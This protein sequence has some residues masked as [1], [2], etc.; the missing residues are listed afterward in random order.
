M[1][2]IRS[3]ERIVLNVFATLYRSFGAEGI[4]YEGLSHLPLDDTR[5]VGTGF[6]VIR[7]EA[8]SISTPHEHTADEMFYVL[9][10]ELID[11][12]GTRYG[13][14]DM[15]LLRKGTQHCS[16]TPD[17][18]MLLVFVETIETPVGGPDRR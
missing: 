4:A 6:H 8:G 9:D 3:A 10:G 17:G 5:P 16:R 7:M 1:K 2:P 11:N 13:K 15:V 14:G 18:C 12:D